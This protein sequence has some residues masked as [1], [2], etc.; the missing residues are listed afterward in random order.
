MPTKTKSKSKKVAKKAENTAVI[1]GRE[2]DMTPVAFEDVDIGDFEFGSAGLRQSSKYFQV[3]QRCLEME[4]GQAI[5]IA[6]DEDADEDAIKRKRLAL[7]QVI[8]NKVRPHRSDVKFRT[9]VNRDQTH[10]VIGAFEV[11]EE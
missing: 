1:G 4:P 10:I 2:V 9:R 8:T 5:A 6:L 3:V 7:G 11:E